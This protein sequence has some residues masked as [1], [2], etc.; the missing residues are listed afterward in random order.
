MQ[1]G[2]QDP[3][4]TCDGISIGLGFDAELVQLGPIAP[5]AATPNPCAD[6]GADGGS[7]GPACIVATVGT[8]HSGA[9][10]TPVTVGAAMPVQQALKDA[11]TADWYSFT[12]KAGQHLMIDALAFALEPGADPN[13]GAITDTF[14][15]LYQSD[16]TTVLAQDD[17]AWPRLSTD[18]ALYVELPAD[19]T[20]Y[21]AVEDCNAALG[22]GSYSPGAIQCFTYQTSVTDLA[23]AKSETVGVLKGA[24]R[25]RRPPTSRSRGHRRARS[26]PPRSTASSRRH[27]HQV[28]SFMPPAPP[29][30]R[31]TAH[32]AYFWLQPIGPKNGDGSSASVEVIVTNT[33]GKVLSQANQAD[34][35]DGD[36]SNDGPMALS[37][38]LDSNGTA[39]STPYTLQI[40]NEATSQK[41]Y[42]DYYFIEHNV[43]V[44]APGQP[45]AEKPGSSTNDTAATA[46][47]LAV[48]PAVPILGVTYAIDGNVALPGDTV[49][50]Y[51]MAVPSGTHNVTSM[52]AA[53]RAGSG[54]LGFTAQLFQDVAGTLSVAVLSE[55][56]PPSVDL[57]SQSAT[58]GTATTL[59]LKIKV[60]WQDP[61]VTGSYYNCSMFF[62]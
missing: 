28:F 27:R 49:D 46:E 60:T 50:W 26:P 29:R 24:A 18:S 37:F 47:T 35:K 38:P 45:E 30:S 13:S 15:T 22:A 20:Y 5:P 17:D 48:I 32:W 33:S 10:A 34:F 2:T 61:V 31:G 23:A 57:Q 9:T 36:T 3:T 59:Y 12:G 39:L 6:A 1:D 55:T 43:G 4:K 7:V 11:S 25:R 8:N 58:F 19:G 42:A 14:V 53:A 62:N 52:C 51:K 54:L 41:P 40:V 21:Y 44:F 16:M 56:S